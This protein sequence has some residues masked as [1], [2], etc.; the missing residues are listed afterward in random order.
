[1]IN[2]GV[3]GAGTVA[4][5]M[6]FPTLSNLP[7]LFKIAAVSDLSPSLTKYISSKY[8]ARGFSS[9]FDMIND[10][11]IDA[12]F[13][14]S[15]DQYH[16][17]YAKAAITANKHVFIEKPV[18]LCPQELQELINLEKQ[19]T[20]L[21]CMVGYMRRYAQGFLKCKQILESDSRKIEYLRFR[22]I[23]LEGD[24]FIDQT[25]HPFVPND[26]SGEKLAESAER[27]SKQIRLALGENCTEQQRIS[28]QMLTGLGCH[29]LS[30]VRELVG[31][32]LEIKSVTA[33][34]EHLVVVFQFDGF[35][36][37]Y[38]L[39]NDQDI[40]QFDAA[41]EIYQHDRYMH[42]KYETPYLRYQPQHFTVVESSKHDSK[43]TTYGPDY[44]DAFENEL[45]V[46]HDCIQNGQKP[47]TSLEDSMDDLTLFKTICEKIQ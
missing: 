7:D 13:V 46:F 12:I 3:I 1:M 31:M 21:V 23:I 6:H 44:H 14:L 26:I 17:E 32:P 35:L 24:Y 20:G 47:K 16:A 2:V 34:G 39:V 18:T 41:I 36:G 25:M 19:H 10:R 30:S 29:S 37:V 9:P 38:E 42:I 45:K 4:Q 5:L 15:P 22:D 27:R 28:Y 43:T 40:V 8:N 33:N 11:E